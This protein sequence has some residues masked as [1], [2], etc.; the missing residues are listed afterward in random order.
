MDVMSKIKEKI[1]DESNDIEE[2]MDMSE[3]AWHEGH[4]NEARILKDIANDEKSH[5]KYLENIIG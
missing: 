1:K 2:Y 5:L 4:Y 3:E